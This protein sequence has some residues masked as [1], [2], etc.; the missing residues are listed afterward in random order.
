VNS[1]VMADP[2]SD[3]TTARSASLVVLRD[4]WLTTFGTYP[5]G[6]TIGRELMRCYTRLSRLPS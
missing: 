3:E 1:T 4:T 2:T 5:R 6:G